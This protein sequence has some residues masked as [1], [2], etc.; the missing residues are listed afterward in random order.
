[1][2][3]ASSQWNKWSELPRSRFTKSK[4]R[5]VLINTFHSAPPVTSPSQRNAPFPPLASVAVTNQ[6]CPPAPPPPHAFS[7]PTQDW[8]P[9]PPPKLDFQG[10]NTFSFTCRQLSSTP[11][12][13]SCHSAVPLRMKKETNSKINKE[14]RPYLK[15][16]KV[17]NDMV[18]LYRVCNFKGFLDWWL[19]C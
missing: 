7:A 9:Q 2:S 8:H 6:H 14:K 5:E 1:M 13:R 10:Q 17:P 16:K 19:Q 4:K 11:W 18:V 15:E 12:F 3:F